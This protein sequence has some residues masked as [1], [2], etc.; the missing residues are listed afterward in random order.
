MQCSDLL[1]AC[2]RF[3]ASIL[4]ASLAGNTNQFLL[5]DS[6][7]LSSSWERKIMVGGCPACRPKGALTAVAKIPC[8]ESRR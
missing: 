4:A 1:M 5:L 2:C 7:L 6:S 3:K 8:H